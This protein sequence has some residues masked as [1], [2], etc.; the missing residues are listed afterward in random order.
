MNNESEMER[1]VKQP[2]EGEIKPAA[3]RL[4]ELPAAMRAQVME[5]L[6]GNTY[7]AAEP[8]VSGLV[9]FQC[10]SDVLYRFRKWIKAL[11]RME[12]GQDRLSQITSFLKEQMP[13]ASTEEIREM[14]GIYYSL[15]SLGNGDAKTFVDVSRAEAQSERERIR[16]KRLDLDEKMFKESLRGKLDAGLDGLA[17]M[18]QGN[19]EAMKHFNKAA[20]LIG[21]GTKFKVQ[22]LKGALDEG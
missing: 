12:M 22:I 10:S 21:A 17:E 20:E 14:S 19:P 15:I 2:G 1:K 5:I 18:F 13:E 9:G 16:Q 4:K 3:T 7:K 8:L 6:T 11:K